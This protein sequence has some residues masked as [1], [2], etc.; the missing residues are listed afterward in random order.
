VVT[1]V[2]FRVIPVIDLKGG[3]AVHAVGGRR[4]QYRT[5]RSV[6]QASASPIALVDALRA[7]L[8]IDCVYIA[9]LDAIEGGRVDLGLYE[10]LAREGVE[11]WLDPGVRD[12]SSIRPLL[13][14]VF[15]GL[16]IVVGLESVVG[17]SELGGIVERAG[18]GRVIF[19][20]DLDGGSP[21]VARGAAWESVEPLG[22]VS[23]V[24]ALGIRSLIV[25]DLQHVGTGRGTG[26]ETLLG[27]IREELSGLAIVVGGGIRGVDDAI[28]LKGGGASAVLVG[29]AIHDGRIG[30]EELGRIAADSDGTTV[31]PR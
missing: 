18:P 27:R 2:D 15:A 3:R 23:Q 30:R 24:A 19:S 17:P 8:G 28:A 26:T 25:L 16:R 4:D 1:P 29:T 21:R 31:M 22:I 6:W 12:A 10:R 7:G 11:I 9:D 20:L 5:L 14:D 13:S